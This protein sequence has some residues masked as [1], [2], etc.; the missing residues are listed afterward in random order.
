[1][2][3]QAATPLPC[4]FRT[5]AF[6]EGLSFVL[7]L[8]VAM[9]V[10]YGLDNPEPVRVVGMAHGILFLLFVGAVVEQMLSQQR[11]MRWGIAAFIASLLPFGTF[12]FV[13]RHGRI[14]A[15]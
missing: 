8:F 5:I 6:L 2:N 7:L 1:M 12:V 14:L 13:A 11:G 4:W 3:P 9:P 10:K 15:R